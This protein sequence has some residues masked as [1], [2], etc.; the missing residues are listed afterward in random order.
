MHKNLIPMD[1]NRRLTG[2]ERAFLTEL[3]A[4]LQHY[5]CL[6]YIDNNEICLDMEEESVIEANIDS[7]RDAMHLPAFA[8]WYDV[9]HFMNKNS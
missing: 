4:L 6:L 1:M 3:T 2:K 5:D 8:A 9:E 7:M